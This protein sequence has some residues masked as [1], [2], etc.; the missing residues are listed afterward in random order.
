MHRAGR[1]PHL[2][3]SIGWPPRW[4]PAM[5]G[6][7]HAAEGAGG[8]GGHGHATRTRPSGSVSRRRCR[9]VRV[10]VGSTCAVA[11]DGSRAGS[12]EVESTGT[13]PLNGSHVVHAREDGLRVD[14]ASSGKLNGRRGRRSGPGVMIW[15]P[16]ALD[17]GS[18]SGSSR[19][20][21]PPAARA[22]GGRRRGTRSR[23]GYWASSPRVMSAP[24]MSQR[25]S[26]PRVMSWPDDVGP[27]AERAEEVRDAKVAGSIRNAVMASSTRASTPVARSRRRSPT[28]GSSACAGT[29][30]ADEPADRRRRGRR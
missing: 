18:R 27:C 29:G 15:R 17:R 5:P 9:D 20:G 11:H 13:L 4:I 1:R 8:I 16:C 28:G 30:C 21:T 22:R 23:R 25:P 3:V 19:R 7:M 10:V 12:D 26:S 14:G 2:D 24:A 6:Q